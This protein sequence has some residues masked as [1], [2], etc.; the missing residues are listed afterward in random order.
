[1]FLDVFLQFEIAFMVL[2][3]L[4][5]FLESEPNAYYRLHIQKTRI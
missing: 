3:S 1:M 4:V 2:I 5:N